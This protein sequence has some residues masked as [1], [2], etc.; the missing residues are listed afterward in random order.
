MTAL[1]STWSGG[2]REKDP[3]SSKGS[4]PSKSVHLNRGDGGLGA[5]LDGMGR[6]RANADRE[7]AFHSIKDASGA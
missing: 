6:G 7:E 2:L 5:T 3:F 4:Q 1:Q